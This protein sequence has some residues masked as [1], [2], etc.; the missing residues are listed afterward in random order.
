VKKAEE[1]GLRKSSPARVGAAG[2]RPI[3]GRGSPRP[4]GEVAIM[5]QA[6]PAADGAQARRSPVALVIV[7]IGLCAVALLCLVGG[8][9][10]LEKDRVDRDA[11][12]FVAIGTNDL[13]TETPAV[14]GELRGDGPGWLW[15]STVLGDGRIE[16]TSRSGE[17]LFVGIARTD[18][19]ERY[20]DGTGYTAI[21]HFTTSASTTHEGRAS[22]DPPAREAFW[23]ASTQGTG[24]QTLVWTPRDGDWSVVFMNADGRAPVALRGE[25][26]AQLPLLRWIETMLLIVAVACGLIGGGLLVRAARRAKTSSGAPAAA[27]PRPA[28][29]TPAGVRS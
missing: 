25:L 27:A 28:T 11:A 26:S 5:A 6:T 9:L 18:D 23:A 15:G 13:H 1:D 19:V 2:G 17:P 12:G 20:L 7:G 4:Q 22:A 8:G 24:E 3:C 16:A 14:L 21:E 10:L 29:G